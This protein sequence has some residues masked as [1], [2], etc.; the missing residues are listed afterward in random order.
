MWGTKNKTGDKSAIPKK[1]QILNVSN[2]VDKKVQIL[3]VSNIVPPN[4]VDTNIEHT[5]IVHIF[6]EVGKF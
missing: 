4:I 2:I 3:N 5:N 1:V 6:G